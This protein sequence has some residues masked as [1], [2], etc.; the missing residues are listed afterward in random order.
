MSEPPLGTTDLKVKLLPTNDN[1]EEF[2]DPL[3]SNPIKLVD[4]TPLT[5]IIEE[6]KTD[7]KYELQDLSIKH[8][9]RG[10]STF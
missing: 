10:H 1:Q 4:S 8:V 6:L 7:P 5:N 9:L 2:K 3:I